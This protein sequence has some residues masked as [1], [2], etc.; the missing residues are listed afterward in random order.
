[1]GMG[2]AA[3]DSAETDRLLRRAQAG[4]R[5]A[6][7]ELFACYRPYL[8][9]VIAVR[10]DSKLRT[11]LDPS[12]IVQEAQADAY[13][14]LPDFLERQ[15][16]PFRLWLQ[17]TAYERLLKLRDQHIG[18]A[19]RSVKREVRLPDRSSL[20]LAGRLLGAGSTPSQHLSRKEIAQRINQALAKMAEADREILLMRHHEDLSYDEISSLL[21]IDAAAAR[22]RYG[23]AL[24]RLQN[25][26]TETGLLESQS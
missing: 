23:R 6:F 20:V 17:K 10:L 8:Q 14:R 7:E 11:R 3:P 25:L 9:Q 12:D 13:R 24:L 19:R 26:L 1:M 22:K 16:M 4:D 18:A 15:P 5:R 2:E 21:E